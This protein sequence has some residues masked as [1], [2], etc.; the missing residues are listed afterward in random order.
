MKLFAQASLPIAGAADA[1]LLRDCGQTDR[2][3]A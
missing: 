3:F 1:M 2:G